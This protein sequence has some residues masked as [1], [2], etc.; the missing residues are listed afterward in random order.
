[1]TL[2]ALQLKSHFLHEEYVMLLYATDGNDDDVLWKTINNRYNKKQITN[3]C[4]K[5]LV[6]S[7]VLCI[8]VSETCI[9][10]FSAVYI[11]MY[12]YQ[13]SCGLTL[14]IQMFQ[15]CCGSSKNDVMIKAI[16]CLFFI[17]FLSFIKFSE[18]S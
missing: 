8:P 12:T 11:I 17:I 7:T 1:M 18:S 13:L 5:L 4:W 6:W 2:T 14:S 16:T 15:S 10:W 3:W 9:I